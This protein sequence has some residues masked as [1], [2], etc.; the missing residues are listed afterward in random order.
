MITESDI[1]SKIAKIYDQKGYT[2]AKKCD[3]L[4]NYISSHGTTFQMQQLYDALW[5]KTEIETDFCESECEY[6]DYFGSVED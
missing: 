6:N 3:I 4:Y 1:R 2:A 5:R